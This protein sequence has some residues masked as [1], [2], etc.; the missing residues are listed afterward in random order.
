MSIRLR[1]IALFLVLGFGAIFGAGTLLW[2]A[3][4][5]RLVADS[6]LA[7][8]AIS[9]RLVEIAGD[10]AVERGTTN[11]VLGNLA[12]ATPAQIDTLRAR[13]T[14]SQAQLAEVRAGLTDPRLSSEAVARALGQV[15]RAVIEVTALRQQ[16]DQA[17]SRGADADLADLRA[18]WFP[19]MTRFVIASLDLRLAVDARLP[20]GMPNAVRKAFNHRAA[21]A[22]AAEYA[23]QERGFLAG[24]IGAGAVIDP[25]RLGTLA[26]V[27]GRLLAAWRLV[28]IGAVDLPIALQQSVALAD[29]TH[30]VRFA[31]VRDQV[32][33]AGIAGAGYPMAADAW[34]A[35]ASV[36]IDLILDAGEAAAGLV[37]AELGT[38]AAEAERDVSLAIGWLVL[39]LIILG[40]AAI[41]TSLQLLRPLR[42]V[43]TAL[44]QVARGDIAIGPVRV[45]NRRD[46][47][48]VLAIALEGF[49]AAER[50][51]RQLIDERE[52]AK[53]LAAEARSL[54]ILGL[55]DQIEASLRSVV[56]RMTTSA[57]A[58][59]TVAGDV[60]RSAARTGDE[61]RS[62]SSSSSRVNRSIQT[63][64]SAAEEL[65]N[66]VRDVAGRISQVAFAALQVQDDGERVSDVLDLVQRHVASIQDTIAGLTS[67]SLI[68]EAAARELLVKGGAGDTTIAGSLFDLARSSGR[69][70]DQVL[71]DANGIRVTLEASKRAIST[72]ATHSQNVEGVSSQIAASVEEQ[73]VTTLDIAR[74]MADAAGAVAAID[75]TIQSVAESATATGWSIR[76]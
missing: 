17:L 64:A 74:T 3:W 44:H 53:T 51:R 9:A 21:I 20:S 37:A 41:T 75:A 15:E 25:N 4:T 71:A 69:Y 34:F 56:D 43:T 13:R 45:A 14:A 76:R 49:V 50:E 68:G 65:S 2:K 62:V 67:A 40:V 57:Q 18:R 6:G 61:A 7:V 52:T 33:Q 59:Q 39:T 36:G 28:T 47:V 8:N 42:Q 1:L 22:D 24:V 63:V 26:E 16:V 27:R 38:M 32:M 54:Q 66:A 72:L 23:G 10:L 48:G 31:I 29:E 73:A 58:M 5:A 12:A 19:A 11:A 60:N 35:A 70:G 46:E 30:F 55:A